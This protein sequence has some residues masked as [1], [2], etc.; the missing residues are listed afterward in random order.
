MPLSDLDR[1]CLEAAVARL[2]E[3]GLYVHPLDGGGFIGGSH[4]ET[5]REIRTVQNSFLVQM[6]D[7][8]CELNLLGTVVPVGSLEEAIERILTEVKPGENVHSPS[9]PRNGYHEY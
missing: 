3:G 6:S 1:S 5:S 4:V 9:P 8:K 2:R 7:G